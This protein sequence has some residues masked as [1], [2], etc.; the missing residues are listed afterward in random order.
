MIKI[1]P[2]KTIS[3]SSLKK[4]KCLVMEELDQL[5]VDYFPSISRDNFLKR[6]IYP[7]SRFLLL[8][9]YRCL[10]KGI[11]NLLIDQSLYNFVKKVHPNLSIFS[12]S[13][14][15]FHHTNQTSNKYKRFDNYLST[16]LHYDNYVD[17]QK[18]G[19]DTLTTWIPFDDIDYST[20]SLVTSNDEYLIKNTANGDGVTGL[21]PAV[22]HTEEFIKNNSAYI[23]RLRKGC[24]EYSLKMG[25]CILFDKS[26]LH[27]AT[28]CRTKDR[29]S[30]DLRWIKN[31]TYKSFEELQYSLHKFKIDA[32]DN[33]YR[34]RDDVF[35]KNNISKIN[36]DF[37]KVKFFHTTRNLLLPL[38]NFFIK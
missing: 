36:K 19:Y 25:Q 17:N 13:Y 26:V 30:F 37:Y 3:C 24:K 27:G 15:R 28:Y 22:F 31:S 7:D 6:Y 12:V 35:I 16:A 9:Q 29:I 5:H 33:L 21:S 34:N 32:L 20:G 1:S 18:K 4:A 2:E 10:F 23:K 38:K 8:L 14:L 11:V